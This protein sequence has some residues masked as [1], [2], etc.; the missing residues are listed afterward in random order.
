MNSSA[1]TG[2]IWSA[3]LTLFSVANPPQSLANTQQSAS[4]Q[5]VCNRQ[6][7]EVSAP[8]LSEPAL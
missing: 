5:E 2:L 8:Q 4:C 1:C 7:Q 6:Q 3:I